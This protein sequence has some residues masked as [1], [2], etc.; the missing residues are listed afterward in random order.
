MMYSCAQRELI[1]FVSKTPVR[2]GMNVLTGGQQANALEIDTYM[3]ERMHG[4][5]H[6]TYYY[7][8]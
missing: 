8:S 4:Q 5:A 3:H 1:A 7:M 2:D 6:N